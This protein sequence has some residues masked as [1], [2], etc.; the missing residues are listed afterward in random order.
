MDD[1]FLRIRDRE[2]ADAVSTVVSAFAA[3]PVERWLYPDD[4]QYADWFSQFTLAFGGKAFDERTAWRLEDLSAVALWLPPG[5]EADG[6]AI[7][8][9][10]ADSVDQAK[11]EDLFATVAQ[12]DAQHPSYSHWYL[13]WL[14]I[15]PEHQGQGL[16]GQLLRACLEVVDETHLPAYLETPNPRT[17]P[18]YERYGFQVTGEAQAGACPPLTL[19]L[20]P[21]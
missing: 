20:R 9:L 10:L 8:E 7:G 4:A 12:M 2:R 6:E 21:A 11:H 1:S 18:F 3:D 16:G 19:M 15:A 14:A 13:A 5:V 17:V